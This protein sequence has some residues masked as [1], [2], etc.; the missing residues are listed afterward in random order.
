MEPRAS[1]S[2][3]F[4]RDCRHEHWGIGRGSPGLVKRTSD[5]RQLTLPFR[6]IG[7]RRFSLQP[8]SFESLL[9]P[10]NIYSSL[11]AFDH[12]RRA[13]NVGGMEFASGGEELDGELRDEEVS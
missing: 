6:G 5:D 13:S 12:A 7:E 2:A 1:L 9:D 8:P 11:A 10:S 3:L 4:C